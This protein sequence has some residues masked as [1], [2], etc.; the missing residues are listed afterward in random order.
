MQ[1]ATQHLIVQ[2]LQ[3]ASALAGDQLRMAHARTQ[4]QAVEAQL[5]FQARASETAAQRERAR[6]F[7]EEALLDS[8]IGF[9]RELV[10]ALID[11]RVDVVQKT[12]DSIL[13]VYAEQARS[14]V[15]QQARV[16]ERHLDTADP[17][18]RASCRARLV[19]I[20]TQLGKIRTDCRLLFR[21]MVQA[22]EAVGGRALQLPD[23][24]R[25]ALGL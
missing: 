2:A 16:E 23:Q 25:N 4:L 18:V 7:H 19:E 11:R 24:D 13:A 6:F 8:Q 5:V 21:E 9:A 20:D 1:P 12:C 17:L 22:L 10:R 3:H 14:Y 15:Q